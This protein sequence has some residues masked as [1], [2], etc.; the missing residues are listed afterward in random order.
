MVG[1]VLPGHGASEERKTGRWLEDTVRPALAPDRQCEC[2]C[3]DQ[4]KQ[5]GHHES[6]RD[7]H[8]VFLP[9]ARP[10]LGGTLPTPPLATLLSPQERTSRWEVEEPGLP[11]SRRLHPA[12]RCRVR[13]IFPL[14]CQQRNRVSHQ[15]SSCSR[16]GDDAAR[17][18]PPCSGSR[19][20]Q[21]RRTAHRPRPRGAPRAAS[22]SRREGS[23]SPSGDADYLRDDN[24]FGAVHAGSPGTLPR[25]CFPIPRANRT[26]GTSSPAVDVR[27]TNRKP[28]GARVR[29]AF[30]AK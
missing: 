22:S 14:G 28:F 7:I 4:Q 19:D 29:F 3:S 25:P 5:D 17:R 11:Q 10:P 13:L 2:A 24:C 18:A 16:T 8:G 23:A 21:L 30:F 1:P 9:S 20:E 12:V 15:A 6:S 27:G 26:P